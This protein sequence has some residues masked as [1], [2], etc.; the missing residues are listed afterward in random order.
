[1][2]PYSSRARGSFFRIQGATGQGASGGVKST[3]I[4]PDPVA[5]PSDPLPY[6]SSSSGNTTA[7]RGTDGGDT[8][9]NPSSRGGGG[10]K[11]PIEPR[12]VPNALGG[13][14][15][16]EPTI[17]LPIDTKPMQSPSPY[18]Q[19]KIQESKRNAGAYSDIWDLIVKDVAGTIT[20]A[21]KILLSTYEVRP[22]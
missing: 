2:L 12:G 3:P 19:K 21:E 9:G 6:S 17:I 7:D 13:S 10:G 14:K 20:Q 16:E 8:D 1:M 11:P 18:V 22:C 5:Y 4:L 15:V